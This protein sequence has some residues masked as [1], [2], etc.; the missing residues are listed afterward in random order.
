MCC[1]RLR[2]LRR[3]SIAPPFGM[4]REGGALS[5]T[6]GERAAKNISGS[7]L[8]RLRRGSFAHPFRHGWGGRSFGFTGSV[9][10]VSFGGRSFSNGRGACRLLPSALAGAASWALWRQSTPR[11]WEPREYIATLDIESE[12]VKQS[13]T[14]SSITAATT[15]RCFWVSSRWL[16]VCLLSAWLCCCVASRPPRLL[17]PL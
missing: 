15:R 5:A 8:R 16:F 14:N 6:A 3:G 10:L 12:K 7:R 13:T 4:A 9:P 1:G 2:Q 17:H 11:L